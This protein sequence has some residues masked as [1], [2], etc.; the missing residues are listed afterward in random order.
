VITSDNKPYGLHRPRVESQFTGTKILSLRMTREPSF[1]LAEKDTYVTRAY[2]TIKLDDLNYKYALGLFNSKLFYYWL[3]KMG[4]RKGKQLQI[5]QAQIMELPVFVPSIE[6]QEKVIEK[7]NQLLY[8]LQ[9]NQDVSDVLNEIDMLIYN[10]Y[11]LDDSEISTI[12]SFIDGLRG[13]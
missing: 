9:N 6:E 7:V 10:L 11:E 12:N 2:I 3:F 5:D 8:L 4:K 1:T 13:V